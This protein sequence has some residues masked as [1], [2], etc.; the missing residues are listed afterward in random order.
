[1]KPIIFHGLC[2]VGIVLFA[3][4][5]FYTPGIYYG[6]VAG[7]AYFESEGGSNFIVIKFESR[8]EK[9]WWWK[10]PLNHSY[11]SIE[12][13]INE[14]NKAMI[15]FPSLLCEYKNKKEPY[16]IN[17]FKYLLQD[18]SED[19]ANL[20]FLDLDIEEFHDF[21]L[22]VNN[23]TLPLP[24]HHPYEISGLYMDR[25]VHFNLGGTGYLFFLGP[26]LLF[27]GIMLQLIGL[28]KKKEIIYIFAILLFVSL[29]NFVLFFLGILLNLF[30]GNIDKLGAKLCQI[31]VGLFPVLI[32]ISTIYSIFTSV[33]KKS[34]NA[35][36]IYWSVFLYFVVIIF[37]HFP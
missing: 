7:N 21:I 23:G 9:K 29:I 16:S 25:Y 5:L 28:F 27:F 14:K 8:T 22:S 33:K 19:K 26:A 20:S 18:N 32:F 36:A 11:N 3:L 13:N 1:M 10:K 12:L 24:R 6:L 2:V 31:S 17:L 37:S 15:Y 4:T 35:V 30:P 34:L